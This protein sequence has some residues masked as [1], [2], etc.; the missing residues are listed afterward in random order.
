MVRLMKMVG[1]FCSNVFRNVIR[2]LVMISGD[3]GFMVC[4]MEDGFNIRLMVK[5]LDFLV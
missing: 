1:I 5:R 2:L 3:F 4:W